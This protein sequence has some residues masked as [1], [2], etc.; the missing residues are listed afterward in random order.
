[1]SDIVLPSV[2]PQI[3]FGH[4]LLAVRR[5]CLINALLDTVK[6]IDIRILDRELAE[7]VPEMRLREMAA[8]GLRA[9]LVYPVPCL[10]AS[11]PKLLAYYRMLL[12]YSGKEFYSASA[13]TTKFQRMETIGTIVED[14]SRLLPE[15]CCAFVAAAQDLVDG[16][17]IQHMSREF[18]DDLTLLTLGPSFRGGSNVRKGTSATEIVRLII[19]ELFGKHVV[20]ETRKEISLV[21][22]ANRKVTV[23]F[24]SD[25]DVTVRE[26][27]SPG[28]YRNVV[29]IEI[30]GGVD[31]SNVHNRIGE[32]EKSHQKARNAGFTECWTIVNVD[33]LD[34]GMANRESPSTDR[35]YILSQLVAPD[36]QE[37]QEFLGRLAAIAGIP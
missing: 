1:M 9:E 15:L 26:E 33:R 16:V 20:F 13:G 37:R 3:R 27:L 28:I 11:K 10:L 14:Q 32:A 18:L 4:A 8:L 17:G 25:P 7:Y 6:A 36:S 23:R 30:K 24:G 19:S 31:V 35:F 2:E 21:N 34:L 5:E 22:A 12:G 29:A